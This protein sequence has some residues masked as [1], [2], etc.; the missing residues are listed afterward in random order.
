MDPA[1]VRRI[2]G[3]VLD[4]LPSAEIAFTLHF[5]EGS[6]VLLPESQAQMPAILKA[7]Q[8]RRSTAISVIGHTDTK[9]TTE[10]NGRAR[11]EPG[12]KGSRNSD[13]AGSG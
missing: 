1:E 5:G 13:R 12:A 11:P 10:S 4:A 8:D 2:F 6:D 7:I 9:G 3:T